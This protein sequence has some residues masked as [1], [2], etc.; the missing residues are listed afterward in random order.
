M[1]DRADA[2][3]ASS[4]RG[5]R[6]AELSPERARYLSRLRR[7]SVAIWAA[8][9]G[10]LV[11]SLLLWEVAARRGWANSFLTSSPSQ[12]AAT[13]HQMARDGSLLLHTRLTAVETVAG[14][15]AGTVLG[16]LIAA[17]LWWSEYLSRV[18]E[19]YLVVLNAMPKEALGPIFIVWLGNGLPAIVAMA[20]AISVVVTVIMVFHGFST[21]DEDKIKLLR[22]FGATRWQVLQKVVLPATFP[23]IMAALKVNVGLALVGT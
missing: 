7:Q 22:T 3:T 5:A 14:F 8:R 10:L 2:V 18:L 17:A 6:R 9:L 11:I 20:L 16:T 19:P 13:L 4:P 21:V 15:T 12:V 1:C 23:T